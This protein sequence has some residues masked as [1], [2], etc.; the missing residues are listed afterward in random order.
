MPN[1]AAYPAFAAYAV[2]LVV[3]SLNLLVLWSYS[4]AVRI[5]SKTTP[6]QEDARGKSS[7]APGDPPEVARVLRAY[8]NAA[9]AILP[10]AVLGL[11]FVLAGG[12]RTA[13]MAIFGAFTAA[14]I[15]HSIA[16]LRAQQ[17]WRTLSFGVG[18]A[19]TLVLMGL[20]VRELF[21]A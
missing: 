12:S 13:G 20:I 5:R 19:S 9:A 11:V 10:F 3:L 18:A 21:V 15:A 2:S 7:V 4:G 16:Y 17:P 8:N 6:N 14:R 1:M